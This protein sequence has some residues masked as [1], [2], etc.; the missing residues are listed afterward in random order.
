MAAGAEPLPIN[1]DKWHDI[2]KG[3]FPEISQELSDDFYGLLKV[4]HI[5][6]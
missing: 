6:R 5:L 2:R 3:N 4:T 1:G